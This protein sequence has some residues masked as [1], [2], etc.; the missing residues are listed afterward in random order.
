MRYADIKS[1]LMRRCNANLKA[2]IEE[3]EDAEPIPEKWRVI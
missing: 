2:I 3:Q 1:L